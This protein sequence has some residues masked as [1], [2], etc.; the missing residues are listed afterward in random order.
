[1]LWEEG[2]GLN[3]GVILYAKSADDGGTFGNIINL[4]HTSDSVN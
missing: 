1:V 4:I 3:R 2:T